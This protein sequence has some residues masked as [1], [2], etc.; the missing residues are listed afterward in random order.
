M[1]KIAD[2]IALLDLSI[3]LGDHH[4]LIHPTLVWDEKDVILVD[5][6][7]PGMLP[8]IREEMNHAGISF[9]RLSKVI[10]THQD[11][12]HIGGLPE[13]LNISEHPI[14]VLAHE[15]DKPF[16]EGDKLLIKHNP[17]RGLPPKAKVNTLI[18]DGEVLPYLGGLTVI[19]TPGHTPGH[20]SL[21]H[22]GSKTLITGDAMVSNDGQ[23]TRMNEKFT[24]DLEL[25]WKSIARFTEFDVKTALCYHGGI[26]D[27]QVNEQ[28]AKLLNGT[29]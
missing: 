22:A 21:Y 11:Y 3:T 19:F 7:I 26:C 9:D 10:I 16:I 15:L 12:D 6:A 8:A 14:E 1:K 29:Q 5:A 13:I 2:G 27:D 4:M 17:A 28:I 23:L 18:C 25:A 20:I 24:P